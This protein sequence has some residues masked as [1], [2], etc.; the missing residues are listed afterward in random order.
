MKKFFILLTACTMG[1]AY[2]ASAMTSD[3]NNPAPHNVEPTV[4]SIV[5]DVDDLV[6]L[7]KD[8]AFILYED[9]ILALNSS[10]TSDIYSLSG[11][12]HLSAL[13]YYLVSI[14]EVDSSLGFSMERF[15]EL[16]DI[17]DKWFH[18]LMD[19]YDTDA[20][21]EKFN[22]ELELYGDAEALFIRQAVLTFAQLSL[23]S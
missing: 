11:E 19:S 5:S 20:E 18:R 21:C 1:F 15:F 3:S 7:M 17:A 22:A 10:I 14:N 6:E 23:E 4:D 12:D 16:S 13:A 9:E 2:N 8:G